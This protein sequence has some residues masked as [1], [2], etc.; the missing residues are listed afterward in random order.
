M[1]DLKKIKE[2]ISCVQYCMQNGISGISREGDR[3]V[4][5]LRPD[6]QNATSFEVWNNSWKDW[7]GDTW[8][9]VIDL[10]A[11]HK[12]GGDKGEAI[13]YL[14][15]IT[16]VENDGSSSKWTEYT[17]QLCSQIAYYHEHLPTEY[18]DYMHKRGIT[19]DTI[20]RLRIGMVTDGN[21]RGR[22]IIPY[23]KNGYV[24]YYITRSM[25]GSEHEDVKYMKM[26]VDDYNDH[27]PWGL[28]TLERDPKKNIA[29]VAEGAFDIMSFEQESA[30]GKNWACLSAITG[31][32][33]G[34][35]LKVVLP[36]LRSYKQVYIIYDN[37]GGVGRTAPGGAGEKFTVKMSRI[38]F[39]EN[40]QFRVCHCPVG[41]KD[42]SDYYAD[43]G[44]LQELLDTSMDGVL[45][46][47]RTFEREQ[48]REL[49]AVCRSGCRYR[50][51]SEVAELFAELKK[52]DRWPEDFLAALRAEC[53]SAPS[54][55][56]VADEV[57]KRHKLLHNDKIGT[58]EYDGCRWQE[59]TDAQLQAYVDQELGV[60]ATGGKVTSIAKLIRARCV[61]TAMFD[62]T[63]VINFTNGTLE[64]KPEIRFREHSE[65]DL[66]TYCAPYPYEPG[67]RCRDWEMFIR[68]VCDEDERK[69]SLLQEVAG[70]VL[71]DTNKMQAAVF[72]IGEGSNGK[73]VYTDT[74]KSVFTTERTTAVPLEK[75]D[76]DFQLVQTATSILNI[77]GETSGEIDGATSTF[78]AVV[79]GDLVNACHKGK[80]FFSFEPRTKFFINC[81]S[82][83]R[84]TDTSNG[85]FRRCVF[86]EFP[87][88]FV[89]NGEP[90][91]PNERKADIHLSEKLQTP[92]ALTGIF[93]WVLEGYREI[94]ATGY[95][96]ETAEAEDLKEQFK[97]TLNPLIVFVQDR[98]TLPFEDFS[99]DDLYKEYVAWCDIAHHKVMSR[100][101]FRIKIQPIM[102][103]YYPNYEQYR[104]S[105]SRLNWRT[106]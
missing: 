24:A 54:E 93:N 31:N 32:F 69:M 67:A 83:P 72:L 4:S 43:G 95:F 106:R 78:K 92:D 27:C 7:G 57:L 45:A 18:R 70:Y 55:S 79:S 102:R 73:S 47:A 62:R 56:F 20:D 97:Q 94:E 82:F 52:L 60:Y 104:S 85:F 14:A 91:R 86:I 1:V 89:I 37:D 28:H 17:Q 71:Q 100:S 16:G 10:C 42:V 25:P 3:C 76:K 103:E 29:I 96:T 8:G 36:I 48:T 2:R 35:Q 105:K 87:L 101:Q 84:T 38:L 66:C 30:N 61:T 74:L 12:F 33:S 39:R 5:P 23:Y 40:I 75:L 64:L 26:R 34:G 90:K 51:K 53:C 46:L 13:R 59:L 50:T 11:L 80:D 6:A 9:D 44:D 63:P 77:C 21:L 49:A 22:L 88:R 58:K 98:Q 65:D 68:T 81:N 99:A 41:Y 15:R 19:D